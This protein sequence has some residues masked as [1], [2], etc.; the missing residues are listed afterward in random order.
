MTKDDCSF[1]VFKTGLSGIRNFKVLNY[2]F[3]CLLLKATSQNI[4]NRGEGNCYETRQ[5]SLLYAIVTFFGLD[6]A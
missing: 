5:S 2:Y 3:G 1:D 4:V 6:P